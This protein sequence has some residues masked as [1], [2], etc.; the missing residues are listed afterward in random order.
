M[1]INDNSKSTNNLNS[2][3][4][5]RYRIF[6]YD[7]QKFDRYGNRIWDRGINST[8]PPTTI[9]EADDIYEA[10][11]LLVDMAVEHGGIGK[12]DMHYLIQATESNKKNN[13]IYPWYITVITL[14][15]EIIW[16]MPQDFVSEVVN[17]V[18]NSEI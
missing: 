10:R 17:E 8:I 9:A 11:K 6:G 14:N 18:C 12:L 2:Y 5:Q 7:R 16:N 4:I 3:L 13:Y 1:T 15:G